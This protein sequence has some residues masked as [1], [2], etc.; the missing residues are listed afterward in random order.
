MK[1]TP[2]LLLATAAAHGVGFLARWLNLYP[3][4]V[5]RGGRLTPEWLSK[6][7]PPAGP[8]F[9]CVF[10]G[11]NHTICPDLVCM[12]FRSGVE[13]QVPRHSLVLSLQRFIPQL[14]LQIFQC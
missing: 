12:A 2:T 10:A 6:R 7:K 5:D 1:L 14:M 9:C 8:M 13:I 3:W 11:K 4:M